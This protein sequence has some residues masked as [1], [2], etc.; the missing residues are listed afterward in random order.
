MEGCN[1]FVGESYGFAGGAVRGI[2]QPF[3]PNQMKT[4]L[5]FVLLVI[6]LAGANHIRAQVKADTSLYFEINSL[7]TCNTWDESKEGRDC[8]TIPSL[9]TFIWHRGDGQVIL[10]DH[11]RDLT[12]QAYKVKKLK[13]EG[14]LICTNSKADNTLVDWNVNFF[15]GTII[16]VVSNPKGELIK[17]ETVVYF[18][19]DV[20]YA[21]E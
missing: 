14:Y 20:Y 12:T 8:E 9:C 18:F 5:T 13:E 7:R 6:G 11:D 16:K 10:L 4:I 21:L 17:S 2:F 3:K 1:L 19:D 15:D